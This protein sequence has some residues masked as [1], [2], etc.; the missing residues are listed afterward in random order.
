MAGTGG[1][2]ALRSGGGLV[3][4]HTGPHPDDPTLPAPDPLHTLLGRACYGI[5]QAAWDRAKALDYVGWL[6]EQLDPAL[7]DSQVEAEV[8]TYFPRVG[9]SAAQLLADVQLNSNPQRAATE[10]RGAALH[11][12]LTSPRQLF[13]TMVEFW[14]DHFN[15]ATTA[16]PESFYKVVDDREVIRA[17]A[18]GYF[19]DMLQAS[20]R[21]LA[22]LYYLDNVSNRASG[23]NENYARELMELHTLGV[24][25]GYTEQDVA[26]VARCFTGW[27]VTGVGQGA[28]VFAFVASRHDNGPKTVLGS[29]IPAGGGINDGIGVLDLLAAHPSTARYIATRLC[30]R[31]I[32][33]APQSTAVDAVA[34]SFTASGGHLPTVMTTLFGSAEFISSYDRKI[35]RPADYLLACL[36]ATAA[37]LGASYQ[38]ALQSRL[39][40]L[41]QLPFR[42]PTPDGYPDEFGDW[43]NSGAML[44]RWNFAF[45]LVENRLSGMTVDVPGLLAGA[46]TPALIV[47]R[48]ADRLLHRTLSG[49]D[50]DALVLFAANGGSIDR[51]LSASEATARGREVAGLLLSS[52]YFNYR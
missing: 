16:T 35:R 38:T 43:V 14:G 46:N 5:S 6:Q 11:R 13:E 10:L 33:D 25:G 40:A 7:D 45:A 44:N 9:M 4:E 34:A 31:F 50:A 12:Q 27:T 37:T 49:A 19:R 47:V 29:A 30:Q 24:D 36:R 51:V 15:I 42:W 28:P 17:H 41:G 21:S 32:G 3:A 22:M 48:L 2:M 23:P 8:A 52:P 18:F 20:A 26:E 39:N 1:G